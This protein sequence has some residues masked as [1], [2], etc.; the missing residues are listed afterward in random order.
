MKAVDKY[1]L[2]VVLMLLLNT[3][4]V[5]GFCIYSFVQFEQR[6]MVAKVLKDFVS[7]DKKRQEKK[8]TL[9]SVVKKRWL[10]KIKK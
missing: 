2:M 7:H 4:R 6:N 10:Q 5:F 1:F 9:S 3:V 8:N